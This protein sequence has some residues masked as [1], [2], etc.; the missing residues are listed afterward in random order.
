M[1]HSLHSAL[2]IRYEETH[3]GEMVSTNFLGSLIDNHLNWR[4]YLEQMICKFSGSCYAVK[5]MFCNS[6][7][8]T[9]NCILFYTF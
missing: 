5:L 9:V 4:N 2:L 1:N 7:F 8:T 3:V 6:N